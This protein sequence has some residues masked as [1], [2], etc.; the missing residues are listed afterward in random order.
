MDNVIID[1][2]GPDKQALAL[3]I[4]AGATIMIGLLAWTAA[5]G[6]NRIA[7]K[8]ARKELFKLRYENHSSYLMDYTF[9]ATC[10][11]NWYRTYY[12]TRKYF[13]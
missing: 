4:Q 11:R 1:L 8:S 10:S 3:F 12:R 9:D 6:Q 2:F 5:N 13:N 7:E